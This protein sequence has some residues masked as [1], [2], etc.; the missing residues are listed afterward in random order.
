VRRAEVSVT[1]IP[2]TPIGHV[3]SDVAEQRD[4]D[5][6][7]VVARIALLPEYQDGLRG[8]EAFSHAIVVT[9]LHQ[10]GFVASRD[11]VRR[12]RGLATMPEIGIFAQRAKDRPNPIGITAV[13]IQAVGPGWVE[14]VGLDAI[15]GTPVLDLKPYVPQYDRVPDAAVPAWVDELMQGYF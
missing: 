8:L 15:D 3:R 13:R 11:L 6:G 14:V 5:W 1:A 10:A 7:R 2:V 12:P 4:A 9:Y